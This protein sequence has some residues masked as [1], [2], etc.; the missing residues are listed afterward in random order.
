[1]FHVRNVLYATDFSSYS[2]QAY[3]HAVSLADAWK[4]RLT[5]ATVFCPV[6]EDQSLGSRSECQKQ[7]EGIRPSNATIPVNHVLLEGDPASKLV[8]FARE[9]QADVMVMGTH[10]RGG[11]D[12]LLMGSV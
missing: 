7:L 2:T 4:A 11:V 6:N 8:E 3:F 1:M 12:R 9:A 10:G 5:I